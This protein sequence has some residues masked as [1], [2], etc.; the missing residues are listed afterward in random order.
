VSNIS[1]VQQIIVICELEN[2]W[3]RVRAQLLLMGGTHGELP[4]A[5]K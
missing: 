5:M 3:V 1:N 2:E 4:T